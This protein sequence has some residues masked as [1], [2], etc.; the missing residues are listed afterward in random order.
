MLYVVLDEQH[1]DDA[2]LQRVGE[3]YVRDDDALRRRGD[4]EGLACRGAEVGA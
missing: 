3:V 4:E 1:V 2:V